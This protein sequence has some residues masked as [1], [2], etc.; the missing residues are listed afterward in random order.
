VPEATL[1]LAPG[2]ERS[3]ERRHPWI[4]R[5][6]IDDVR[7]AP[8]PGATTVVR[9][10]DGR[11]LAQAAFS[12]ASQIAAR[13]WTWDED[14]QVD[15]AFV[16][17][18]VATS[19]AARAELLVR[20]DA[21][22]LTFAE[23]DGLPGV[24]ADRY[25]PVVVLQLS[26]TGADRWRQTLAEA[27]ASLPGVISLYER[28]DL[29]VRE[30][31]GLGPRTGQLL[32]EEP[33][34]VLEIH[35]QAAEHEPVWRFGVDVRAGHKTGFY[36]DQRESRRV[37]AG[38]AAGRRALDL[39]CYTGGF[40]VAAG[41]GGAADLTG[42]DSSGS[43]LA[44]AAGNLER[45]GVRAGELVDAD[46]FTHLR[47]LRDA[48][49]RYDLIVL[50]PPRLASGAAQLTRATRAYKDL[51]LLALKLLTPGGLL[52]TFSCSGLVSADLFQKIVF[53]A[54]LDAR[55]DVQIIGRLAQASDHPVL[56]TFPEASYL[57]G[58][59]CRAG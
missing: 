18:R 53:G 36:L 26:S 7:G 48:A 8:E 51:N 38:L 42:V 5:G 45:N 27:Y 52:V 56:L 28:S 11:F 13:I 59:V 39:F 32:G 12:P 1:L 33:P 19:A 15:D 34:A 47:R 30:R 57:K 9:A 29:D 10:S 54:A 20:T 21:A 25:G 16:A 23:S 31:E 17:A 24:I 49:R 40:S 55:R 35:E 58:L 44:L 3:V 37:V 43:A 50:D 4:F 22:R 41:R 6:A 2:R 14:D 46:V